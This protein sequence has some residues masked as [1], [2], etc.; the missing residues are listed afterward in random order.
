M[1]WMC[2]FGLCIFNFSSYSIPFAYRIAQETGYQPGTI[3]VLNPMDLPPIAL[4]PVGTEQA[5]GEIAYRICAQ[6]NRPSEVCEEIRA[7]YSA[8]LDY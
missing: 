7:E 6:L 5:Y 4:L 1:S 8:E 3:L 2:A